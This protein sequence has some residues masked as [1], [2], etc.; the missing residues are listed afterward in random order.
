M[1]PS[2]QQKQQHQNTMFKKHPVIRNP[3]ATKRNNEEEPP[4]LSDF[5]E[6]ASP[7]RPSKQPPLVST[8]VT[9]TSLQESNHDK[10]KPNPVVSERKSE[11][12]PISTGNLEY[13]ERLPSRNLSFGSAEI[14]TVDECLTHASLY[15][16]RAVR[17]T[18][19]LKERGFLDDKTVVLELIHP[20]PSNNH[21]KKR[22]STTPRSS[23]KKSSLLRQK[24]KRPWF[25]MTTTTK[26]A[27]TA[28]KAAPETLTL[29][30]LVD[31]TMEPLST[32]VVGSLV[33][34]I[35]TLTNEGTIQARLLQ[36]VQHSMDMTFYTNALKARRKLIHQRHQTKQEGEVIIQGCGPPPYDDVLEK[37]RIE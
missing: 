12:K 25:A 6:L 30:V 31:V 10:K 29:K 1:D 37:E 17:V 28:M 32:L 19:L 18:G 11:L 33:M 36:R 23:S 24:R 9:T 15:Q 5:P 34:V 8:T 27:T 26:P 35:G 22:S 14:L 2:K 3:Y 16:Q 20:V 21:N 4:S 7:P 13:W